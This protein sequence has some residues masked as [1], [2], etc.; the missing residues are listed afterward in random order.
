MQETTAA[1][2]SNLKHWFAAFFRK[3]KNTYIIFEIYKNVTSPPSKERKGIYLWCN[4][5][6][7]FSIIFLFYLPPTTKNGCCMQMK[8]SLSWHEENRRRKYIWCKISKISRSSPSNIWRWRTKIYLNFTY[9]KVGQ[10]QRKYIYIYI[11]IRKISN[12]SHSSPCQTF[13]ALKNE[14]IFEFYYKKLLCRQKWW[15]W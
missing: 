7:F 14:D 1:R 9:K 5:F 15:W 6:L 4:N 10:Q 13:D 11:Y 8:S 12:I 2:L 3:K